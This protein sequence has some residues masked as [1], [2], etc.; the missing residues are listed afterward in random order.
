MFTSVKGAGTNPGKQQGRA[1]DQQLF[2][3][4]EGWE[5]KHGPQRGHFNISFAHP[6]ARG[7]TQN[8]SNLQ[9]LYIPSSSL[10]QMCFHTPFPFHRRRN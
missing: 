2:L 6:E 10:L 4:N 5:E 1:V 8:H 3:G 9:D 7:E